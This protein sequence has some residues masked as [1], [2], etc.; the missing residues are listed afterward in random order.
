MGVDDRKLVQVN[1][2]SD[3]QR[4]ATKL[5]SWDEHFPLSRTEKWAKVATNY[6]FGTSSTSFTFQ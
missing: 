3:C 1:H 6:P 2:E 5:T 4:P